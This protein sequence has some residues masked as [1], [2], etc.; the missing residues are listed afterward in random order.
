LLDA[1]VMAS[2]REFMASVREFKFHIVFKVKEHFINE[3]TH[4]IF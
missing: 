4:L 1:S 2:V 3:M